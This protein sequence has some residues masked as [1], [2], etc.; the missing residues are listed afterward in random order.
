MFDIAFGT[1]HSRI[2]A[3]ARF[4]IFRILANLKFLIE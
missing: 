1:M 2:M 3:F 4:P